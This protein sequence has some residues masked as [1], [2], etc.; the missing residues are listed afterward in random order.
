MHCLFSR[1]ISRINLQIYYFYRSYVTL[2]NRFDISCSNGFSTLSNNGY[3]C[4]SITDGVRSVS[5]IRWIFLSTITSTLKYFAWLDALSYVK[6]TY[7]GASLNELTDLRLTCT[8]EDR[9]VSSCIDSGEFMIR[10]LGLD[11]MTIERRCL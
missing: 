3:E 4:H 1:W 10:D 7:I 5:F 11:S 9:Q 6:Y 2:F 8:D